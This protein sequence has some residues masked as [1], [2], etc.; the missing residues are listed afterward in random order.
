[1]VCFTPSSVVATVYGCRFWITPC[2]QRTSA[3][4]MEM[5]NRMYKRVD[6][7]ISTQKLPT[8]LIDWRAN[9]RTVQR[10][11]KIPAAADA[12]LCIVS[13]AIWTK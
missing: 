8:V 2:E 6:R 1:M 10:Q 12:K 9:P 4:T 5:G 11:L 3:A 7:V 13:P